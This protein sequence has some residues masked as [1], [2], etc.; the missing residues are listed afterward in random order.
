MRVELR[1]EAQ[2][3]EPKCRR[4]WKLLLGPNAGPKAEW[5]KA[6]GEEGG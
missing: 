3:G 1:E 5:A 2:V 6:A 4:E